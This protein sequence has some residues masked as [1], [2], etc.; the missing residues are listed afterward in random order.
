MRW[1]LMHF[2]RKKWNS[3]LLLYLK[4]IIYRDKRPCPASTLFTLLQQTNWSGGGVGG[5]CISKNNYSWGKFWKT[6]FSAQMV[7][8]I[9]H[10]ITN[11]HIRTFLMYIHW[12]TLIEP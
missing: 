12:S 1:I 7:E 9:D 5:G 2:E 8:N 10:C 6:I 4:L 3:P 11:K